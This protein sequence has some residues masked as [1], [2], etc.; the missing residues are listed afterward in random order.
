MLLHG[1]AKDIW[2]EVLEEGDPEDNEQP[3]DDEDE[4]GFIKAMDQYILQ[5]C[6]RQ[7]ANTCQLCA[8]GNFD[9]KFKRET[10][11][12]AHMS[13]FQQFL[14]YTEQ[15]P[16]T[17]TVQVFNSKMIM[18]DSFPKAWKES[19]LNKGT[20]IFDT[21]KLIDIPQQMDQAATTSANNDKKTKETTRTSPTMANV[22][23]EAG[24][25]T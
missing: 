15:L 7:N 5:F 13:W 6:T 12:S 19:F 1:L 21:C 24:A 23:A 4:D 8:T 11:V 25:S 9:F 22:E 3:F 17:D 18:F 20:N 16:G 10:E 2:L 14:K